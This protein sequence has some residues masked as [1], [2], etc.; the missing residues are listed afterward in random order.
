VLEALRGEVE[1]DQG[2]VGSI[3]SLEGQTFTIGKV[4]HMLNKNSA[5]QISLMD[6][7]KRALSVKGQY[8]AIFKP[9]TDSK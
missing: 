8:V 7:F 9:Q 4:K 6:R 1:R 5:N 3:H 2:D